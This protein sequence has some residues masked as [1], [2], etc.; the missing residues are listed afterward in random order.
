MFLQAFLKEIRNYQ[1]ISL[2]CSVTNC[3]N[4]E[5][6]ISDGSKLENIIPATGRSVS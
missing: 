1:I 3:P 4:N 2:G 6:F 5:S